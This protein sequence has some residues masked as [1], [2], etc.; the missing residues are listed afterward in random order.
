MVHFSP[1]L[2]AVFNVVASAAPKAQPD[3]SRRFFGRG[4]IGLEEE[5]VASQVEF[6]KS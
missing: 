5:K 4:V 2:T 3:L 1:F 6:W